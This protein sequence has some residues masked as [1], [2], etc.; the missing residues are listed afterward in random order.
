MCSVNVSVGSSHPH[1][2]IPTILVVKLLQMSQA[3]RGLFD[4]ADIHVRICLVVPVS[5]AEFKRHFSA[6]R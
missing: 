5:S 4:Q 2:F 1:S 6:L 3:V